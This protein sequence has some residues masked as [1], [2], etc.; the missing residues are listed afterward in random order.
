MKLRV[1]LLVAAMTVALVGGGLVTQGSASAHDHLIPKTVLMKG[2][3]ELLG[4][5]WW[6]TP[7]GPGQ[8]GAA[9]SLPRLLSIVGAGP[10]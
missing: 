1:T 10:K 3:R 4:A 5:A 6:W 2:S 8:P 7:P 9:S